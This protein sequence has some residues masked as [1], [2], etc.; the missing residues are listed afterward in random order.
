MAL[1]RDPV[2][3]SMVERYIA[4]L[5]AP[6]ADWPDGYTCIAHDIMIELH[7]AQCAERERLRREADQSPH[8]II[9]DQSRISGGA[10]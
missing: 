3:R 2:W 9:W 7:L 6:L 8:G 5:V 1:L 4:R 10:P